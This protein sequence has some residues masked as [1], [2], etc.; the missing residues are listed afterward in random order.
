[1]QGRAK[2][3]KSFDALKGFDNYLQQASQTNEVF[4]QLSED[5]YLELNNQLNLISIGSLVSIEYYQINKYQVISGY[6]TKLDTNNHSISIDNKLIK[7]S[8]I[9]KIELL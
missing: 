2:I 5:D 3:F 8:L 6:V 1:M 9:S 7:L 4:K